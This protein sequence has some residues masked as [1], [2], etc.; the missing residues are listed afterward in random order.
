V[1]GRGFILVEVLL[2]LTF[3]G[4][5]ATASLPAIIMS[6]T[7]LTRAEQ[8]VEMTYLCE[9]IAEHINSDSDEMLDIID[10]V[11][12]T[13]K[14]SDSIRETG[15]KEYTYNLELLE[16][17]GEYLLLDLCLSSKEIDDLE[18]CCEISRKFEGIHPH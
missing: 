15:S 4:L 3:L 2:G 1:K 9:Y 8:R 10:R 16:Y 5:I 11:I 13:G 17:T 6:K 18:V 14:Y 7:S 12:N